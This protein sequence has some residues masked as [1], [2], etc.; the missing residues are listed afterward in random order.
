MKKSGILFALIL[1]TALFTTVAAK[2]KGCDKAL[3]NGLSL[4]LETGF[5]SASYGLDDEINASSNAKYGWLLGLQLGNRW[6]IKPQNNF[7]FGIMVNW[8]DI[9][10]ATKSFSTSAA[11]FTR[12]TI[13]LTL[14]EFGPIGTFAITPDMAIDAYY[15]LRPTEL[16]SIMHTAENATYFNDPTSNTDVYTGF[17]ASHAVGAAFRWKVL[18]VGVEY[19]LGS[20]KCSPNGTTTVTNGSNTQI[21]TKPDQNIST[22]SLRILL[23]VKF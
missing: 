18:N 17:G 20:V 12:A 16:I 5:P 1:S 4:S 7:G 6:Y 9:T 13:D 3:K 19:V 21:I 10:A 11:D 23:G 2:K 15:N 8:L 22:N 14:I